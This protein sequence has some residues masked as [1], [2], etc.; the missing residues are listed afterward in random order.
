MDSV[1]VRTSL[2]G[3]LFRHKISLTILSLTI[4][5]ALVWAWNYTP[6]INSWSVLYGANKKPSPVLSPNRALGQSFK[7]TGDFIDHV[8]IWF[9]T[10]TE[11]GRGDVRVY[12]LNGAG[13]PVNR[14]DLER[15]TLVA[16]EIKERSI[17]DSAAMQLDFDPLYNLAAG[18]SLYVLIARSDSPTRSP[19]SLW[20]DSLPRLQGAQGRVD[21][22]GSG[23]ELQINQAGQPS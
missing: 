22:H 2:S 15:R 16:K 21:S 11:I 23:P 20:T 10:Y 14:T 5:L 8:T 7:L 13:A 9:A 3:R 12:L 18:A 6:Q 19:L 1:D 4:I 17:I